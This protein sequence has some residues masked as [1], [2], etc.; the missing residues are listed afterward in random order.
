MIGFESWTIDNG[1][2]L[3]SLLFIGLGGLIALVQWKSG[4]D[5]KRAEFI[6]K[7][8]ERLWFDKNMAKTLYK[9]DYDHIVY[10][11]NFH[12]SG[13][14]EHNLD[15]LL[16]Y[17]SYICYLKYTKNITKK[18]FTIFEYDIVQVC[19][20]EFTQ[21]Y[22]WN[23][24]HYSKKLNTVCSYQYLIDYSIERNLFSEDFKNNCELFQK[25]LDF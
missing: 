1:L 13:S 17:L 3:I 21:A 20:S 16:S 23:Y 4:I 10:D 24:Y 2:T 6:N 11:E 7:I 19:L 8:I 18:E 5:T 15:K 14:L 9:L 22:L 25:Y 12:N